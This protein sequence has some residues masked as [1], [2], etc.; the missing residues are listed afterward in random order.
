MAKI[1]I[2]EDDLS[3]KEFYM[4]FFKIHNHEHV[5]V[6]NRQEALEQVA[7][8]QPEI[9][10]SDVMLNQEDGRFICRELKDMNQDLHIVLLSANPKLLENPELY[11]ASMTIEKPF[12]VTE[13][14]AV[15][16]DF[17]RKP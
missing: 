11:G 10:L 15:I 4:V 12:A 8:F 2:L 6:K 14:A 1:L 16:N 3:L 17:T 9:I 13:M 5:F 7:A